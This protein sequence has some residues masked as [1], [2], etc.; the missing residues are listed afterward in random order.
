MWKLLLGFA[1]FAG[2]SVYLLSEGGA[3][4][5]WRIDRPAVDARATAAK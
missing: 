4:V 1:M 2:L 3:D 5:D